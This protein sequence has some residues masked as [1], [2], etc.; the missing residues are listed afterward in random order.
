MCSRSADMVFDL[1]RPDQ[2]KQR[3]R[4]SFDTTGPGYGAVGDFHW[5]FASR[6]VA[7]APIQPGHLVVDIATGT[8]PA[9]IQAAPQVGSNGNIIGLDISPGMLALARRNIASEGISNIS[10]VCGDA[11]A[12]PL[13]ESRIDGILCSSA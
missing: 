13:S 2:F 9:A 7:H 6:L 8:A 1:T 11:E 4:A 3:V 5:Q 10:L 12:L